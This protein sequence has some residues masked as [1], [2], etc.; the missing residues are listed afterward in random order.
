M[1]N[2]SIVSELEERVRRGMGGRGMEWIDVVQ[3]KEKRWAV[4]DVVMNIRVP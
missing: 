2:T 1:Y 3:N 4:V